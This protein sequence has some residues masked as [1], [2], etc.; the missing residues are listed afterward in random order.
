M[1][2]NKDSGEKS[3]NATLNMIVV[4]I[5]LHSVSKKI[6]VKWTKI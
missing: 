2:I 4:S 5:N 1:D 6:V 3:L